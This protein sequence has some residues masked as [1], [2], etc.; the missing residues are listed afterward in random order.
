WTEA[1]PT[2]ATLREE[3]RA[4]ETVYNTVRPHQALGYRTPWE[5]VQGWQ[6]EASDKTGVS[7]R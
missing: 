5:A 2:V 4:W 7:W 3:L 1:E 6:A